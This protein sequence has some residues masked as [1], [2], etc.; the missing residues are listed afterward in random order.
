M[1]ISGRIEKRVAMAIPVCLADAEELQIANEAVT[2]NVSRHG[3]RVVSKR[4]WK[5][6]EEPQLTVRSGEIRRQAKVVY[7]E[8]TA[9]G[10]FCVGLKLLS[11]V[12]NWDSD[13]IFSRKVATPEIHP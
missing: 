10:R 3:A 8:P 7:C 12:M 11:P 1:R 4:R 2:E 5:A 9:D 6:E 13:M